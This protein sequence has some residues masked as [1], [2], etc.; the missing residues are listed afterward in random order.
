[1]F[2]VRDR[3]HPNHFGQEIQTG[4]CRLLMRR[5]RVATEV[6]EVPG[7]DTMTTPNKVMI[8]TSNP[9]RTDGWFYDLF[10]NDDQEWVKLVLTLRKSPV[11]DQ[12]K[13]EVDRELRG[14]DNE[15]YRVSVLGNFH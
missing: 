8:T 13:L 15:K 6:M 5:Q 14:R 1:M 9:T 12:K 2:Y 4:R 3:K 11:V 10:T 7:W